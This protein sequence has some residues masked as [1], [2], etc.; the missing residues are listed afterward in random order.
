MVDAN[1]TSVLKERLYTILRSLSKILCKKKC[2]TQHLVGKLVHHYLLVVRDYEDA[3]TAIGV[4][5]KSPR[6]CEVFEYPA[7]ITP[8]W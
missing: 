6:Q 4:D 1:R 3:K 8:N 2:S 5:P 7:I